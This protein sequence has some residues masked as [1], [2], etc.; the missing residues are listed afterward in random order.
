MDLEDYRREYMAGGLQE[1]ELAA[2]PMQ[3]FET[4]LKQAVAAGIRDPTAM[5][6]GTVGADGKP[7]Q[8][9][10]LLKHTDEEAF[11]FYTNLGSRKAEEIGHNPDVCLL[12]PWYGLDRQVIIGGRAEKLPA[13]E[14]LKYFA[15]RPRE[16][17]LAAWASRQ[18]RPLSSRQ[19]LETKFMEMKKR[20]EDGK[21]PLPSFWGGY[22][23]VPE[24]VEF[25][26]GRANRMH[27]R[28]MF[29][30]GEAGWAA[31]RLM[32]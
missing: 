20:F 5:T 21:V 15:T 16:S 28:F 10:V 9:T 3:Q 32:P 26:Q 24:S 30:R 14:A 29:R 7:W 25:W 4:W 23:V 22:R 6:V 2:T 13:K 19:I 11:F 27:D 17:Q 8:R 18:S 12:F 31:E 1:D